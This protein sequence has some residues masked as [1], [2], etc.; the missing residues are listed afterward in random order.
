MLISHQSQKIFISIPKTGSTSIMSSLNE[1][2]LHYKPSIYH[3]SFSEILTFDDKTLMNN[4]FLFIGNKF[5]LSTNFFK[6]KISEYAVYAVIRE[7]I[8]RLI[9]VYCDAKK[10]K[11]HKTLKEIS[12]LDSLDEFCRFYLSKNPLDHPRHLWPQNFFI[13]NTPI[14]NLHLYNFNNLQAL[15][16]KLYGNFFWQNAALPHLRRT[17]S[18]SLKLHIKSSLLKKLKDSLKDD[19]SLYNSL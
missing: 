15:L 9:S 19:Y 1:S 3:A 12:K 5:N 2:S 11:N 8:E 4:D 6:K 10:D 13:S 16:N 17:D 18:A 7:P 14:K